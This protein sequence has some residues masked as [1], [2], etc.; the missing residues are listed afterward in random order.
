MRASGKI[1]IMAIANSAVERDNAIR[2]GLIGAGILAFALTIGLSE[3]P[4]LIGNMPYVIPGAKAVATRN[5]AAKI[6]DDYGVH[7]L[8]LRHP[9]MLFHGLV[10]AIAPII[11]R[12]Q[13]G[14]PALKFG[15]SI[16]ETDVLGMPFWVRSD[17]GTVLFYETPG[18]YVTVEANA[19]NLKSMGV[20]PVIPV[21]QQRFPWW[22]HLWGWLPVAAA[23]AY[24]LFEL[25]AIRR[26]RE[27]DGMI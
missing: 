16:V 7:I 18:E 27:A 5:D 17:G 19:Y 25:G 10:N 21:E 22:T 1:D 23:G 20:T 2:N 9:P 3:R 15:S 8:K 6:I 24:G 11:T 26:K 13:N 14:V 4:L 12:Q